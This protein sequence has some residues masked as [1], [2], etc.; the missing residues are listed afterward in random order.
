MRK[1]QRIRNR[2]DSGSNHTVHSSVSKDSK[3]AV[4]RQTLQTWQR[5]QS[6]ISQNGR[7]RNVRGRDGRR[8]TRRKIGTDSRRLKIGLL[9]PSFSGS[10]NA[11]LAIP[12][13]WNQNVN[14]Q[15]KK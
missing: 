15:Q 12:L 14:F 3:S 7:R 1:T 10:D 8:Q 4:T 13:I 11:V 5:R 9:R 2:R 6:I